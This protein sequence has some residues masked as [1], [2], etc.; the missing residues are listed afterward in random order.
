MSRPMYHDVADGQTS[1]GDG[2][3]GPSDGRQR[4]V[5]L[6]EQVG[7]GSIDRPLGEGG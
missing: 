3:M 2:G 5:E 4:L 6:V 1:D 7:F